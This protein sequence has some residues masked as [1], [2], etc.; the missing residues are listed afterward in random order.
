MAKFF[1]HRSSLFSHSKDA[2]SLPHTPTL[3]V[4]CSARA[5]EALRQQAR[6]IAE[7]M[8]CPY[9]PR[10][11]GRLED[12]AQAQHVDALIVVGRQRLFVH[13]GQTRLVHHPNA[14]VLRVVNLLRGRRDTLVDL[15][16][17][18]P[19]DRLLD[20]TCG[21]GSDAIAAAHAVGPEG[22][23]HALEASPLLA[24]LARH[25]MQ[26]YTHPV[27]PAV[28][29]AMRRVRIVSA[30]YQEVLPTCTDAS[31]DVVYFDPM[32]CQTVAASNGLDLVRTFAEAGVPQQSDVDQAVRV[33]R[34]A[35][36]M[37][38]AMPGRALETLGFAIV[39]K[40]R[41]FCFGRIDCAP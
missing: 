40:T 41:R 29:N 25:G 19:G 7:E 8:S 21:L 5:D 12:A 36:L 31:F 35:V 30:R 2:M 4:T 24:L 28:T 22:E 1:P 27:H 14:A 33:A 15:A 32:F 10:P 38:D 6:A 20:C 3:A 39:K 9:W 13:V 16:G 26:T 23:V 17:L 37:K 18:A 11:D 34:R